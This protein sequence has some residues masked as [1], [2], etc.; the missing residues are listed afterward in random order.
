MV[1]ILARGPVIPRLLIDPNLVY[2]PRASGERERER[3][4][5]RE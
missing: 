3:E 2:R 5:E 4:R 1:I